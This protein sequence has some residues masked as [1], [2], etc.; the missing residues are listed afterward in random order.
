MPSLS[1]KLSRK[2][3]PTKIKRNLSVVPKRK[4]STVHKKKST[5][6]RLKSMEGGR[7]TAPPTAKFW[8]MK[9]RTFSKNVVDRYEKSKT[10][11]M[12]AKG[13]C[14]DCDTKV[15]LIVKASDIPS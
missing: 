4:I 5:T 14:K 15:S 11:G 8:C 6:R 9:C 2:K 3:V 10:G 1:R 7:A 13:K 12:F